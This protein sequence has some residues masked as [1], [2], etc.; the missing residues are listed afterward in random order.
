MAWVTLRRLAQFG[1]KNFWRNSWLSV[2]T[3]VTLVVTLFTISVFALQTYVIRSQT[4][5]LKDKLDMSV[6]VADGPS[7]ADVQGFANTI[8][9]YPNVSKVEFLDKNAV[10]Q[11]WNQLQADSKIKDLVT[12]DNNPLPRTI[13]IKAT[14][15]S[16][17]GAI[18]D[19]INKSS[20]APN[21]KKIS[22]Q[23]NSAVIQQLTNDAK[24]STKDGIILG[25]IFLLISILVVYNTI[26]LII[27]F[28]QEE[29]GIMKLVGANN[30][31]V[32]GPFYVEGIFYGIFAGLLT[33]PALYFFLKNNLTAPST[34]IGSS[35]SYVNDQLFSYYQAHLWVIAL[36][37]AAAAAVIA[38]VCTGLSLRRHLKT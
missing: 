3:I 22:Y 25:V 12:P 19:K 33:V 18:A 32:R 1:W 6:Y 15:P 37:L 27:H 7:D 16:Y 21:V 26:R 17:L 24:K 30:W 35:Q 9:Q 14:D 29:I 11:A 8:K 38:V 20:F 5:I 2:A 34:F 23:D 31:F 36:V 13:K 28:R 4:N 10:L